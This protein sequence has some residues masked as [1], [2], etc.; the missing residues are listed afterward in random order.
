MNNATDPP[1]LPFGAL[2]AQFTLG[3]LPASFLGLPGD[4]TP[5]H[6]NCYENNQLDE[7]SFQFFS[8]FD[9]TIWQQ[10]G[11]NPPPWPLPPCL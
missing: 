6:G 2:S 7:L 9:A 5:Y 1:P 4:D 11:T 10:T 3:T 8:L